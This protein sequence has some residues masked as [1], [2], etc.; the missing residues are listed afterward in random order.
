[1]TLSSI[2]ITAGLIVLAAGF[3]LPIAYGLRLRAAAR[4]GPRT[5]NRAAPAQVER[6][7]A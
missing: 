4:P 3:A 5:L 1:M 2:L 7:S 6:V